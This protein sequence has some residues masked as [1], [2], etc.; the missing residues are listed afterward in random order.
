MNTYKWYQ[1]LLIPAEKAHAEKII[2]YT[3]DGKAKIAH[4]EADKLGFPKEIV[5]PL[6]HQFPA[7]FPSFMDLNKSLSRL[8]NSPEIEPGVGLRDLFDRD[9]SSYRDKLTDA[10]KNGLHEADFGMYMYDHYAG[11]LY[12]IAPE[13]WHRIGLITNT[14]KLLT[15]EHDTLSWWQVKEKLQN[16][17]IGIAGI[18]VGGNL[19]EGWMREGRPKKVKVADPDWLEIT[20]LNRLERGSLRHMTQSKAQKRNS[21]NPFE[22]AR[23]NKAELAAYEH[24]LVDPYADWYTYSEGINAANQD[25][26]FLGDGKTEPAIDIFVEEMDNFSLKYELREY[27]RQHRIPVLMLS[28]FGHRVQVQFQDFKKDPKLSLGY[29]VSDEYVQETVTKAMTTGN[30]DDVFTFVRALCG[31]DFAVDEFNTWIEGKGEQPTSSLP[32]SG[33]T[34]MASGGIGGKLIALYLLGY[35]IPPRFTIDLKNL[36]LTIE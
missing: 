10:Q 3:E 13:F 16:A 30:R 22:L 18:S 14:S 9:F 19:L 17:V 20:N 23:V 15:D 25:Q 6:A 26:F 21:K 33:G 29:K 35:T 2:T 34:A 4:P 7:I 1:P 36:T 5:I 12:L 27:C 8:A 32:Q 28:D 11:N 24:H 31:N